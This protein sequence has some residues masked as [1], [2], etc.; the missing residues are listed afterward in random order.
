M[1][2]LS[3]LFICALIVSA[4]FIRLK[5]TTAYLCAIGITAVEVALYLLISETSAFSVLKQINLA[6]FIN[7]SRLFV[8]Y[9]NIN[10]FGYPINLI[11]ATIVASVLLFTA[12]SI[13][14]EVSKVGVTFLTGS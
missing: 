3:A 7:T 11:G 14:K 13:P 8:T 12:K 6:A 5:N 9:T 4:L 2:K 10:L 1:F